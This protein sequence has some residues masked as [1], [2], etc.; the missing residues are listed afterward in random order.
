M[1]PQP[2]TTQPLG[3]SILPFPELGF[4]VREKMKII[5]VT[6][7]SRTAQFSLHEMVKWIHVN[8]RPEL[9]RQVTNGQPARAKG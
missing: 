9:A 7:V 5:H 8:I 2:E 1:N 3:Q 6:E 4:T